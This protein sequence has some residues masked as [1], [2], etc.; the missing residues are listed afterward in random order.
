MT[1]WR[2]AGAGPGQEVSHGEGFFFS[3]PLTGCGRRRS[4]GE[5]GRSRGE[6]GSGGG[7]FGG[8]LTCSLTMEKGFPHLCPITE[9]AYA[10]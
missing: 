10:K 3:V 4:G 9:A 5:G 8:S 1:S 6:E 2:S 7:P